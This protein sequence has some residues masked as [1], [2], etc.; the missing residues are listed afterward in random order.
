MK[1]SAQQPSPSTPRDSYGPATELE[2][3]PTVLLEAAQLATETGAD[4]R[5]VA[6]IESLSDLLFAR[7]AEFV[8]AVTG[9]ANGR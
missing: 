9:G 5:V 6:M 1:S 4:P 8:A 7:P 2:H 3:I